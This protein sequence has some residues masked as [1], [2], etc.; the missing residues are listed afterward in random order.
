MDE[1]SNEVTVTFD[2]H[3]TVSIL[4]ALRDAVDAKTL[5]IVALAELAR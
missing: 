3:D 4:R 5:R 1:N 2:P